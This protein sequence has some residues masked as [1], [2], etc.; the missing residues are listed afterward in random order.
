MSEGAGKSEVR[1]DRSAGSPVSAADA[2]RLKALQAARAQQKAQ[3][4]EAAPASKGNA[5]LLELKKRVLLANKVALKYKAHAAQLTLLVKKS[6][7]QNEK[8]KAQLAQSGGGDEG[9]RARVAEQD[10]QL[11]EIRSQH[12]SADISLR[13]SVGVNGT[14]RHLGRHWR[15]ESAVS[16]AAL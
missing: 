8:L 7:L 15:M 5:I 13:A 1:A 6:R 16:V 3:A 4:A 12:Q 9:L 10:R 11:S 14:T 2:Q